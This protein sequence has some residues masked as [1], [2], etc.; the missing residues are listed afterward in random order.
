MS[1]PVSGPELSRMIRHKPLP[2]GTVEIIASEAER[3]AL[4]RRFA[5]TAVDR[6]VARLGP[7]TRA[8]FGLV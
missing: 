6:L 2:G 7:R 1:G 4:A 5:I 3:V 8:V